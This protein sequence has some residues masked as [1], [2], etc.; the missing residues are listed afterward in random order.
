MTINRFHAIILCALFANAPKAAGQ[1]VSFGV[2]GG[3]S[4]TD[5][6]RKFAPSPTVPSFFEYSTP[7]HYIAGGMLEWHFPANLSLEID[8]LYHPLGYTFAAI[9][10]NGSLNSVSPATVVTW[11]FP[12]LAKY[13]FQLGRLAMFAE[14][15]AAFR[16]TGNLNSANPSHH[17][18]AVGA[19]VETKLGAFRFSPEIRYVHWAAD[20]NDFGPTTI[21]NQ[22]ELLASFSTDPSR[23]THVFGSRLSIGAIA[24]ATLTPDFPTY[25]V[26][27][28]AYFG[29][30]NPVAF[31]QFNTTGPRSFIVGPELELAIAHGISTE[32][33]AILRPMR[34]RESQTYE[35]GMALSPQDGSV[36]TWEFPILGKYRFPIG[37]IK[38]FV[39]AGPSFRLIGDL[40]RASPYGVTAGVGVETHVSRLAIAPAVRFTHWGDN[41]YNI[42]YAAFRNE[43]VLVAGFSF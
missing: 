37:R 41:T 12:V 19:G 28:T 18:F 43:A 3:G 27:G 9:E 42:F 36:T 7:K 6:F 2:V 21:S 30:G 35:D 29:T 24:G 10:P 5:D 11:E 13:R 17:G 8:G 34:S 32:A 15:G 14:G 40:T 1:S 26:N 33:D 38:P 4:V 16:T 23:H 22:V 20:R 39:E 31:T 25:Q